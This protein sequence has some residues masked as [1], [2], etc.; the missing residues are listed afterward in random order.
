MQ[1]NPQYI[2][3]FLKAEV[4]IREAFIKRCILNG[5]RHD[6]KTRGLLYLNIV[7]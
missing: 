4:E 7:K 2:Y 3:M 6:S 1:N 5:T